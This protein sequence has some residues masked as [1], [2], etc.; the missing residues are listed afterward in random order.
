M[1]GICYIPD[2][3]IG[4]LDYFR[5]DVDGISQ[6]LHLK[7]FQTTSCTIMFDNKP[8]LVV[9]H[10]SF[11]PT[12]NNVMSNSALWKIGSD[13]GSKTC[14]MVSHLVGFSEDLAMLF[15][16]TIQHVYSC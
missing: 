3:P 2:D 6:K 9:G 15:T 8:G 12:N 11:V 5:F 16:R 1:C 14:K 10:V 4:G 7:L 13:F